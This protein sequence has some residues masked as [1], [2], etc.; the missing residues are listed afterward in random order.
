M[1]KPAH[2]GFA[3][4]AS[5]IASR[6]GVGMDRARAILAA[7]TRRASPTAKAANPRLARVKGK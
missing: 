7:A 4:V 5:G 2:P 1:K 3:K 6:E